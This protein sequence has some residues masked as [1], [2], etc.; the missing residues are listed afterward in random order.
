MSQKD[1]QDT[2]EL[3]KHLRR[4]SRHFRADET[5]QKDP[6]DASELTKHLRRN[7]PRLQYGIDPSALIF[8]LGFGSVME[9]LASS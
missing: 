6:Q 1:P 4:L 3:T 2:S 7:D 8:G 5:S 9:L